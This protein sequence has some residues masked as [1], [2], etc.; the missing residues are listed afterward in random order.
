MFSAAAV[1]LSVPRPTTLFLT[2]QERSHHMSGA[3][4]PK[5]FLTVKPI[6][7]TST[8]KLQ[9]YHRQHNISN[10]TTM[11]A[12]IQEAIA[13]LE[14]NPHCKVATVARQFEISRGASLPI[15]LGLVGWGLACSSCH[16][17]VAGNA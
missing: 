2:S 14:E 10:P 3:P 8:S 13:F 17:W 4:G 7:S 6:F 12:R 16:L 11:G 9:F 5:S 1:A 15:Q